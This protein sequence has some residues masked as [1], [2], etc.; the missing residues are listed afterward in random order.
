[1]DITHCVTGRQ[2]NIGNISK[3]LPTS[4]M[5]AYVYPF[6]VHYTKN[7]KP[8]SERERQT[9]AG[10]E[11]TY[12]LLQR[13]PILR[14]GLFLNKPEILFPKGG[15]SLEHVSHCCRWLRPGDREGRQGLGS[16]PDVFGMSAGS[17]KRSRVLFSLFATAGA[18]LRLAGM[19]GYN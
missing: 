7:R 19:L 5:H 6:P 18:T 9:G 10:F 12:K 8:F 4:H 16:R 17:P 15:C 13:L 2:K 1:M 11:Q 14:D 3:S